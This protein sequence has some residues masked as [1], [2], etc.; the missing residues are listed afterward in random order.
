MTEFL[1]LMS[2]A[3]RCRNLP[4]QQKDKAYHVFKRKLAD[5]SLPVSY[6]KAIQELCR[7]MQY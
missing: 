1:A 3:Q 2:K 4:P 6:E 7:R 5:M